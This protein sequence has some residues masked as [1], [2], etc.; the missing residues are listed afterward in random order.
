[1]SIEVKPIPLE[2]TYL[3]EGWERIDTSPSLRVGKTKSIEEFAQQVTF[4]TELKALAQSELGMPQGIA[5][6]YAQSW[7]PFF[8]PGMTAQDAINRDIAKIGHP[9]KVIKLKKKGDRNG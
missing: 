6:E 9:G 2:G 1:M 4:L 5:H 7:V 3:V 8:K